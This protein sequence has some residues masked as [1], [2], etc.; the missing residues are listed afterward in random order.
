MKKDDYYHD[1][2]RH[3]VAF[4]WC[5]TWLLAVVCMLIWAVAIVVAITVAGAS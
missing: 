3:I 4:G 2:D 1:A 5:V